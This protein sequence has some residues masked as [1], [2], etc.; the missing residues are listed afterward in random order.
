MPEILTQK[1]TQLI[2]AEQTKQAISGLKPKQ[3]DRIDRARD[4]LIRQM[5]DPPSILD[6][7]QQVVH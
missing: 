1:F 5:N 3:I 6:L 2:E 4:I 7:A